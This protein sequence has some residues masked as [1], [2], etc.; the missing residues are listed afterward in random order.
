[1]TKETF[2][3]TIDFIL[4]A[5]EQ[6]DKFCNILRELSGNEFYCDAYIYSGY[7]NLVVDILRKDFDDRDDNIG[8][9]LYEYLDFP[10][11]AKKE[12]LK[13]TPWFESVET[14][15]EYLKSEWLGN[16]IGE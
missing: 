5:R 15:Y 10:E 11:E 2:V 8:Y 6:E 7:E 12:Q 14:L 9:Y 3:K 13:E 4:K 16:N 1:M